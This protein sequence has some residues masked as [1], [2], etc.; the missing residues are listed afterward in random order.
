VYTSSLSMHHPFTHQQ[1]AQSH[2]MP[3]NVYL[4]QGYSVTSMLMWSTAMLMKVRWGYTWALAVRHGKGTVACGEA[5]FRD[6]TG[7]VHVLGCEG[8]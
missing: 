3:C 6:A 8:H 1:L 7:E 5:C 4:L 2:G